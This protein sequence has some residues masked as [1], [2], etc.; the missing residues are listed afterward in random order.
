MGSI[1]IWHWI[2]VALIVALVFGTK[3][4]KQIGEDLGGAVHG[5]KKEL[6][7]EEKKEGNTPS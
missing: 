4:L 7:K 3:R 1:S 2:I 6:N 5:F